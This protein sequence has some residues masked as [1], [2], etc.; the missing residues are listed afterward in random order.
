MSRKEQSFG[1]IPIEDNKVLLVQHKGGHWAFPKGHSD[2][3]ETPKETA[4]RE[5]KEETDLDIV[6][7]VSTPPLEEHYVF[8]WKGEL[9]DKTVTY[10]VAYV[11]GDV[12]IQ[13]DELIGYKWASF[14][15]AKTLATFEEAKR[16]CIKLTSLL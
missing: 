14:S 7:F 11:K 16:I 6:S 13:D 4:T 9:I 1:I 2:K 15:E 12:K 10:F 5:L 3:N 8:T